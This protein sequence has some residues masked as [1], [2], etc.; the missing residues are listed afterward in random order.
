MDHSQH[1]MDA[2]SHADH[3]MAAMKPSAAGMAAG[4][5]DEHAGHSVA[6]FRDK[7]WRSVIL[8]VPVLFWSRDPQSWLHYSAPTFPG[9]ALIPPV[10]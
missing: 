7:F 6:M 5:H 4:G 2:L 10:L 1:S 9:S 8:T 3:S